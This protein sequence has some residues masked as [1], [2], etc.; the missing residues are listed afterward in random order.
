MIGEHHQAIGIREGQRAQQNALDDGE[1][2]GGG[3]YAE[4]EHEDGGDG[5]AKRFAQLAQGKLQIENKSSACDSS[6]FL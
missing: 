3:A 6:E 4:C 2:R 5:E 1:D